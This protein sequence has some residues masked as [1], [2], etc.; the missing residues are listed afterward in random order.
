[1][2][3][4]FGSTTLGGILRCTR[5]DGLYELC[6][7]LYQQLRIV[8]IPTVAVVKRLLYR[9]AKRS[10][11]IDNNNSKLI[12]KAKIICIYR[13][14]QLWKLMLMHQAMSENFPLI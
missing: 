4:D 3:I 9:M 5:T 10:S 12:K 13:T 1:M 2:K 8:I 11:Q 7:R 6:R 14:Y